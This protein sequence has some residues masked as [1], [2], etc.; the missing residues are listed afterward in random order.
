[1]AKQRGPSKRVV[2]N[3]QAL[4]AITLAIADAFEPVAKAVLSRAN[5]RLRPHRLVGTL[6][7]SAGWLVE[8]KGRKVAGGGS[9]PKQLRAGA[10]QERVRTVVGYGAPHAHLA[11]SGT[12]RMAAFPFLSPSVD[13]VGPQAGAMMVPLIKRVTDRP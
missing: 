4:D 12:I 8:V 5:A 11:E 3:R 9:R 13:E 1:M 2:V 10:R 6:E 7:D